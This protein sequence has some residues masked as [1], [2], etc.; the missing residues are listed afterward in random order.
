[1][2]ARRP[3]AL[4]ALLASVPLALGACDFAGAD[5]TTGRWVGAATFEADTILADHNAHVFAEYETE[6][7]FRLTDDEGLVTGQLT[8]RTTGYRIVR[9]AGQPADTLRFEDEAPLVHDVF[10]TYIDP[11]LEVD[12]PGGPYE[13]GL[14]TFEV[15]GRRAETQQFLVHTLQ[16]PLTNGDPFTFDIKSTEFFE[17]QR[18]AEDA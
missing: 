18:V 2:P 9:E 13:D 12:V 1:M 7:T 11:T 3:L 16:I 5:G 15:S 14:W 10:G 6:F 8:S 17:M 4:L